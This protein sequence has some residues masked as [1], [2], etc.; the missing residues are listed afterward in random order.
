MSEKNSENSLEKDFIFRFQLS[1]VEE[2]YYEDRYTEMIRQQL[3]NLLDT[4]VN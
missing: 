3:V 1:D 4:P 2:A